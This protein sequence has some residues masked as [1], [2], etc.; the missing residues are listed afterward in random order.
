M[1]V[2]LPTE[3]WLRITHFVSDNDLFRLIGV[4]RLF[5]DL[6]T[7]RRYRQLIID[8]DRPAALVNKI[9]RIENDPMVAAR[10]KSL[11]IHP[12]AVRSACI[13]SAKGGEKNVIRPAKHPNWPDVFQRRSQ[14]HSIEEDVWLADRL[15]SALS[16]LTS[17]EEYIVDWKR[18]LEGERH[19]CVPLLTAVCG[20][21]LVRDLTSITLHMTIGQMSDSIFDVTGLDKLQELSLNFTCGDL[22]FGPWE[23]RYA[24][25][26]MSAF[27]NHV[28]LTLQSLSI[29]S[30][31]HM[32]FSILYTNLTY[33]P[34]LH[35]LALLVPCDPKH[36]VDPTGFHQFLK[37]HF[38]TLQHVHFSPQYCCPQSAL[39]PDTMTTNE[40]MDQ[41]FGGGI[42]LHNLQHLDLGLNILGSGGKRVMLATQRFGDIVSSLATLTIIGCVIAL[43]D[44]ALLL[45]PFSN[46]K[47][48]SAPRKLVLEVHV[49]SA[50]VLDFLADKLPCLERLDLTYRWIGDSKTGSTSE[51]ETA[52]VEDMKG[53]TYFHWKLWEIVLRCS[54]QNDDARWPCQQAII[55]CIPGLSSGKGARL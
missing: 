13:R 12:K 39:P 43:D 32:D 37:A 2:D 42:Q 38:K 26:K 44:L 7:D 31:G 24:L 22:H 35:H 29:S 18:G 25:E 6:V 20:P 21:T 33:F 4:N 54:R 48:G 46:S 9:T 41:C 45:G 23:A 1:A 47:G 51:L 28:A 53:R 36:V 52:F 16:K 27:I 50:N 8:D 49:L 19:F 10:V 55:R 11:C 34:R 15:L 5:F 17:I 3:L 40:W 14:T 30:I